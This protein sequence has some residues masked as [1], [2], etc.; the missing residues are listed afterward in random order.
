[1]SRDQLRRSKTSRAVHDV[2]KESG[3]EVID[4]RQGATSHVVFMAC[5]RGWCRKFVVVGGKT[6][7]NHAAQNAA[8]DIAKFKETVD[9]LLRGEK[10]DLFLGTPR[11]IFRRGLDV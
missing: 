10:V 7:E 4:R 1:M 8:K 2:F 6:K 5:Y 3:L 9:A 11:A